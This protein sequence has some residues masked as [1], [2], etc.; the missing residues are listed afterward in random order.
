MTDMNAGLTPAKDSAPVSAQEADF[1][2]LYAEDLKAD[3]GEGQA[4][5]DAASHEP[6]AAP[7]AVD[8]E[9]GGDPEENKGQFVRHGAFYAEREKRKALEA[10]LAE[11]DIEV[12]R[13]NERFAVFN[14]LLTKA[15]AQQQEPAAP[16]APP[17]LETDPI[18]YMKWVGEELQRSQRAV[19]EAQQQAQTQQSVQELVASYQQDAVSFARETPDFG[20]AYTHLLQGRDR[21]LAL[22]GY[23]DQRQ[24]EAILR[25]EEQEL[26]K[27]AQ[28]A[29]KRP[30]Q[31]VYELAQ[32]RGYT[33]PAPAPAPAPAVDDIQ[34]IAE[35][36]AAN[37][38]LSGM[39]GSVGKTELTAQ[40]LANMSDAEFA[41]VSEAVK[42]RIMGG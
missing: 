18:G 4:T 3:S 39:S 1:M 7:D 20:A 30:A 27:T 32:A 36:Q 6:A 5:P 41:S 17:S 16:P 26:V 40:D 22:T 25:H 9:D 37:R 23:T 31:L 24:R 34:R 11:R 14:D 38:S 12:A 29:G 33:K 15:P 21:E 42:R 8:P 13:I 35:A 10:K 2:A 19:Q 28:K